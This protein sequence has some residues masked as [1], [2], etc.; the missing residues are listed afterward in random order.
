MRHGIQIPSTT[1]HP[2]PVVKNLAT[3]QSLKKE[4]SNRGVFS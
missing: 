4:M 1:E 2:V 3:W